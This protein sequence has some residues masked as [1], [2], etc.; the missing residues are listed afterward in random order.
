MDKIRLLELAGVQQLEES[1]AQ[2]IKSAISTIEDII[3]MYD[4]QASE[5]AQDIV[6]N[7][8]ELLASYK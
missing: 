1:S 7:L 5:D 8:K 6:D 2:W 4:E 3:E